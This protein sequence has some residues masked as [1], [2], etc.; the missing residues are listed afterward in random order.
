MSTNNYFVLTAN[1]L[2]VGDVI[3]L[4]SSREWV[5]RFEQAHVFTDKDLADQA[6]K[7]AEA[8]TAL[9]GPYLAKVELDGDEPRPAH[10]RE[11][12]RATGPSNYK[13][14]KQEQ[15]YV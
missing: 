1:D 12:F 9:I 10:F 13:H 4:N 11:D 8:N 2:L 7:I 6:L 3:Y 14:G 5:R 15:A